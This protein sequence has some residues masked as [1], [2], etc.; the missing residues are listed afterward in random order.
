MMHTYIQRRQKLFDCLPA[1]AVAIIPSGRSVVRNRDTEY[2]F[3]AS[4]DFMY[5]TGFEEP[6]C[7]LVLV[8][9][10]SEQK[11]YLGLRAKD[12]EKEI[13]DGYRLGVDAAPLTLGIDDA[14]D[15]QTV[16]AQL[17]TL[18]TNQTSVWLSFEQASDWSAR[19][20]ALITGLKKQV[21]LGVQ[22]PQGLHDLDV[23]L[24]EQRLIK[25]AAAL[26]GLIQANRVTVD[27]HLA[28]MKAVQAGVFEYQ[29]QAALEY[30]CRRQGA[31]RQAFDSIVASGQNACVLHYHE[32]QACLQ[33]GQLILID[34]GAEI[35][36]YAGDCT[37]TFPVDGRFS[38]PQA[39]L[40]DLVL[41]AQQAAL[42]EIRP[43]AMYDQPHRAAVSVL[44]QGMLDLGLLHGE[45]HE[46]IESGAYKRFYMHQTGHWL[47]CDVHDVGQYKLQGEW[48]PLQA[49]MALT[50]EPGIYISP[51]DESVD[52]KW[53][54]IGI[55][56]EDSVLVTECGYD[57]L[58]AG[59][60]RTRQEIESWM[61]KQSTMQLTLPLF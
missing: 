2:A 53:R 47:G 28:A 34:A 36:G 9:G 19:L 18:L 38:Q 25:D 49:H 43:G 59:L 61:K 15:I 21:R 41:A 51:T 48:R 13:W 33:S 44:S 32:N 27:A 29:V 45:L 54:G 55:R 4:S 14:F 26:D 60:P 16:E 56:I 50:V 10:L 37:H 6:D 11:C 24:H 20:L 46:V 39:A 23:L 17:K 42:S 58:T 40:Y 12:I 8:K 52:E 30:E 35:S 3:R 22:A 31:K 1:R 57:C 5:L 7:L